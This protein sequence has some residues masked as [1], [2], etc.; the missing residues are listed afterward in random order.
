MLD[1]VD[2]FL[3][4][5]CSSGRDA[6]RLRVRTKQ[7]EPQCMLDRK[8]E[9]QEEQWIESQ[10]ARQLD[11]QRGDKRRGKPR[12]KPKIPVLLRDWRSAT[13]DDL[14]HD[15]CLPK[16]NFPKWFTGVLTDTM[17]EDEKTGW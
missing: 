6:K 12:G 9:Q 10:L 11:E 15:F 5:R 17:S 2:S 16:F 3:S 4:R 13:G 8:K 1:D 7:N 14:P